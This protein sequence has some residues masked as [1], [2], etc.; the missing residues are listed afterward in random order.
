MGGMSSIAAPEILP[1][2]DI[3]ICAPQAVGPLWMA[4]GIC[5]LFLAYF[6][7]GTIRRVVVTDAPDTLPHAITYLSQILGEWLLLGA[8][9]ATVYHRRVFLRESLLNGA[10]P[11]GTEIAYGFTVFVSFFACDAVILGL[12]RIASQRLWPFNTASHL[13]DTTNHWLKLEHSS[14]L[15]M[16]PASGVDLLLWTLVCLTAGVCEELIFRGY[17]LRQCIAALRR[18]ALSQNTSVILAVI[19]TS[20]LF[21]A[22]HLYEGAGGALTIGLLSATYAVAALQLGN[23]RVV[24]IAHTLQDLSFGVVTYLNHLLIHQ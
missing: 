23:L 21:G 7:I 16:G 2:A 4:A 8:T 9:L 11:W 14:A 20:L 17:L 12:F 10:R 19:L 13:I 5:L 1:E 24:I 22:V 18:L 6:T 3:E 15:K